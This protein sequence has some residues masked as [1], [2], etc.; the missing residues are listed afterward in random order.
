MKAGV[1]DDM[2]NKVREAHRRIAMGD[3][4]STAQ[5]FQLFGAMVFALAVLSGCGQD[6]SQGPAGAAGSAPVTSATG[7]TTDQQKA[8]S[9]TGTVTSVTIGSDGKPVVNFTLKDSNGRGIVGLGYT[10]PSTSTTLKNLQ[11]AMAQLVPGSG[12]SPSKWVSYIVTTTSGGLQRPGT[13]NTGTLVDHGDGSYTYTFFRSLTQLAAT[14]TASTDSGKADLGS[15]S[16]LT[17]TPTRI[18]RLVIQVGGAVRGTGTNTTDGSYVLPSVQMDHPVDVV[19]DFLPSTGAAVPATDANGREIVKIDKCFECHSRFTFHQDIVRVTGFTET[20]ADSWA[21]GVRQDT[22]FCVVCHTDQRKYGRTNSTTT[23]SYATHDIAYSG[24]VYRVNDLAVGNFPVYIHKIHM[25]ERLTIGNSNF[26][27]LVFNEIT[28]PQDVRNCV[29]CHDGTTGASNATAQGDHWKTNPNRLVCTA[30]H[31]NVD[32]NT[33]EITDPATGAV[34][35][36]HPGGG[37]AWNTLTNPDGTCA[38]CHTATTDSITATTAPI[39]TTHLPVDTSSTPPRIADQDNLPT[40]TKKIAYELKTASVTVSGTPKLVS[41]KFRILVNGTA[42]TLGSATPLAAP[43]DDLTGGPSFYLAYAIPQDGITNPAD[44]NVSVNTSL[45]NVAN[46]QRGTIT[47]GPD[48]DGYYT[49]TIGGGTD[50]ANSAGL[51]IP[52][53]ATMVTAG[54][55]FGAFVQTGLTDYPAG[56]SLIT[57]LVTQTASGYTARRVAVAKDNCNKC[58]ENLG[59]SPTFHSGN[60]NDPTVCAFC[61]TPWRSSHGWAA[62]SSSFI[63]MIHGSAKRS[64]KFNW[65]ATSTTAGFFDVTFPGILKRCETCHVAGA[66][67]YDLSGSVYTDDFFNRWLYSVAATGSLDTT[68]ITLSSWA[69]TD[70]AN[71]SYASPHNY[72]TNFTYTTS[73]GDGLGTN[74]QDTVLMISPIATVCFACHDTT[75]AK[76]HM[77]QNGASIY[78]PRS[79]ALA[80]KEQCMICHG[81]GRVAAIKDMHA[82]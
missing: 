55:G 18:H 44:F 65:H 4:N 14:Y 77:E 46:G 24:T 38:N 70:M 76:A 58:H 45:A 66:G 22:R 56:L 11:F 33:G 29:K 8:L 1:G 61:H 28:F 6:G 13:D 30:C 68:D 31:D 39:P 57:S 34:T 37:Q 60:R 27:G 9:V 16:D 23:G 15:L 26:A 48:T 74:A 52:A 78:K 19:Y 50:A 43:N 72:G 64:V 69:A 32:Y 53:N 7:L 75:L 17:Y 54:F 73:A 5:R 36:P 51:V 81:P 59:T 80:T 12:G 25:A 2:K 49:A 79:T 67:A 62:R 35:S 41:L 63:H 3:R 40:G 20:P 10:S 42:A 82:K 47:A 71:N 21:P